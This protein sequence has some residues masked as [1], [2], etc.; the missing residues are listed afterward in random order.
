MGD[1]T[2]NFGFFAVPSLKYAYPSMQTAAQATATGDSEAAVVKRHM[3]RIRWM[4][5]PFANRGVSIEDLVQ[6][7]CIALLAAARTFD[8]S[9]GFE[10]WTY[11]R[12]FVFKAIM[13]HKSREAAEPCR[14]LQIVDSYEGSDDDIDAPDLVFG[15]FDGSP[16]PEAALSTRQQIPFL[17]DAMVY[18]TE[19]ERRIVRL[20][21]EED[22]PCA[23]IA[24]AYALVAW[25]QAMKGEVVDIPIQSCD[26]CERV[27]KR[28]KE[29]LR[30]RVGAQL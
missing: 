28:A 23:Q 8:P 20:V 7:G 24:I 16:T 27:L 18:L 9:R 4:A 11:A 21:F 22:Q 1:V 19:L 10:L 12:Q 25:G 5:L 3:R 30:E 2:A 29:K 6:E 26:T 17:V 15:L 14:D 13:S